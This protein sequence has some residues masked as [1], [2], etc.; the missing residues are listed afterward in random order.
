MPVDLRV[1]VLVSAHPKLQLMEFCPTF[2]WSILLLGPKPP[3]VHYQSVYSLTCNNFG[4]KVIPQVKN[5]L[6][7]LSKTC[8]CPRKKFHNVKNLSDCY[9]NGQLIR[10]RARAFTR[11]L[12]FNPP[13]CN[14]SRSP[15]TWDLQFF[16]ASQLG[17][18]MRIRFGFSVYARR[19][20]AKFQGVSCFSCSAFF[21][22]DFK[23]LSLLCQFMPDFGLYEIV[24]GLLFFC[25]YAATMF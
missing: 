7:R 18:S 13:L 11:D 9:P 17:E 14:H 23:E 10:P 1:L 24:P 16:S 2:A 22:F 4:Q 8:T 6:L 20:R 15:S 21:S 12:R 3:L 25:S 19:G 5:S